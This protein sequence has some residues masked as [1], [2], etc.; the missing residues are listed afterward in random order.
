MIKLCA[1]DMDGTLLNRQG[2]L[3][4]FTVEAIKQAQNKGIHFAVITGRADEGVEIPFEGKGVTCTRI[5]MN[6]AQIKDEN[7]RILFEKTIPF[8]QI[9]LFNVLLKNSGF[10]YSFYGENCRYTFFTINQHREIDELLNKVKMPDKRYQ[11]FIRIDSL[12]E[13]RD[14][15]I[16]KMEARSDQIDQVAP[17][18]ELLS[19]KLDLN[20]TSAAYFNVEA[21]HQEANKATALK[22]L[23]KILN[24]EEDETAI[25]G[26][27]L[28]D[29]ILF[30]NFKETYAVANA[31][32]EVK[33]SAKYHIKN[34]NEDAVAEILNEF[35]SQQEI[36]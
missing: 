6:G 2:K 4:E 31:C 35:V 15:K 12:D 1:S 7:K 30:Q 20:V 24:V 33:E 34:H 27:G 32:K 25:F 28:N 36:Y 22:S 21:T 11:N 3:T 14:K 17:L 10:I 16:F 23:C 26:D 9:T 13:L 19:E 5:L 18:R 8:D 29:L